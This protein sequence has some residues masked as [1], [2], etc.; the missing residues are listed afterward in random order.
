MVVLVIIFLMI[1]VIEL[2][3]IMSSEE[4]SE[5]SSKDLLEKLLGVSKIDKVSRDS[6]RSK[7]QY[8]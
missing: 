5:D 4:L 2:F 8:T 6:R 3:V 7:S 1:I